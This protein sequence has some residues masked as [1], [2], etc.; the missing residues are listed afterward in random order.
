MKQHTNK[1]KPFLKS[2][3]QGMKEF[4]LVISSLV[5]TILLLIVYLFGVGLTSI[6]A[7]LMKKQFLLLKKNKTITYWQELNLVKKP[8]KE[9]Y[10]Q[11]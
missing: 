6:A 7:R 11:F 8:L 5:N 2:F 10:R 4:A 3:H 9:Y 1:V